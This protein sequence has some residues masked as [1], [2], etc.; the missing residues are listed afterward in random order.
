MLGA[1]ATRFFEYLEMAEKATA[2][3]LVVKA[4]GVGNFNG[5][6]ILNMAG[7]WR[8]SRFG[9]LRFHLGATIG[10]LGQIDDVHAVEV[11]AEGHAVIRAWLLTSGVCRT[12]CQSVRE[13]FGRID[14]PSYKP[15]YV[16]AVQW[17][18]LRRPR[19]LCGNNFSWITFPFAS[20]G[21][22]RA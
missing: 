7:L 3:A 9:Q 13:F 20:S 10:S 14:N 12:D 6:K 5:R 17:L 8:Q 11:I 2:I 16:I 21:I 1:S 15:C 22:G 19:T 18:C 4:R